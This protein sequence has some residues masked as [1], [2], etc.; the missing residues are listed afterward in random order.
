MLCHCRLPCRD[1]P[2]ICVNAHAC[3][4][5]ADFCL[6]RFGPESCGDYRAI[7]FRP[8][9]RSILSEEQFRELFRVLQQMETDIVSE[10][11]KV[12]LM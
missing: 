5:G 9:F 1:E 10:L 2:W 3:R 8:L 4:Q 11:D 12:R 7:P 6:Y